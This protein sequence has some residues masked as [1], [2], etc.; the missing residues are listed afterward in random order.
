MVPKRVDR[1][2]YS[3]LHI[4][5]NTRAGRGGMP[6]V[7]STDGCGSGGVGLG[8]SDILEDSITGQSGLEDDN[9]GSTGRRGQLGTVIRGPTQ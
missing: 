6:S 4:Q 7:T 5:S 2:T 8:R 9:R 3:H 1:S